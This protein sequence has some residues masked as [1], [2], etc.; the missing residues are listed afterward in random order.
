MG[1]IRRRRERVE[2]DQNVKEMMSGRTQ[3]AVKR[4]TWHTWSRSGS[5]RDRRHVPLGR[6]PVGAHR[7][8]C[9]NASYLGHNRSAPASIP[10]AIVRHNR[11]CDLDPGAMRHGE[12]RASHALMW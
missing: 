5:D 1:Q 12:T 9:D 4:R 8:A 7:S 10:V 6:R 11:P 2:P 3:S